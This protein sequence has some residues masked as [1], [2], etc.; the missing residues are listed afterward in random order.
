MAAADAAWRAALRDVSIADL[1]R[2][3]D[4]DYGPAALAGIRDW[5]GAGP[6]PA[7]GQDAA[8]GA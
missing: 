2:G 7:A 6:E 4:E 5:L 3:V 1:A 8:S